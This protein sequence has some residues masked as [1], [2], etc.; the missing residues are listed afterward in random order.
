MRQTDVRA[1]SY[2]HLKFSIL[3]S[4]GGFEF[5]KLQTAITR[6]S[7]VRFRRF[8][9]EYKNFFDIYATKLPE[10]GL[11]VPFLKKTPFTDSYTR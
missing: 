3:K 7:G 6:A 10:G 11:R 1:E 9:F 2:D 5:V 8:F 4:E